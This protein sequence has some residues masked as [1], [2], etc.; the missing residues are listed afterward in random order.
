MGQLKTLVVPFVAVVMA[1]W[2]DSE[3]ESSTGRNVVFS[4]VFV[5]AIDSYCCQ[6]IHVLINT[7]VQHGRQ[8]G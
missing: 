2:N 8:T 4:H 7:M 6:S 5:V 3:S 1:E